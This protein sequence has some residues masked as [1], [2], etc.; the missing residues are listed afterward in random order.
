MR[1]AEDL[2]GAA[3]PIYLLGR[4]VP[5]S[6][7]IQIVETIRGVRPYEELEKKLNLLLDVR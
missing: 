4:R 5:G 7:A 1:L 6:D 3:T 2:V